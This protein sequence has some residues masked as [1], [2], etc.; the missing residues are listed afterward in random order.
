MPKT[1]FSFGPSLTPIERPRC[2]RCSTGMMLA[3]IA[4]GSSGF[5]IRTFECG[6]C[7]H[8][9]TA[10]VDIDPMKS[11]LVGGWLTGELSVSVGGRG[12]RDTHASSI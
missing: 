3:R 6:K 9:H 10:A 4:P 1:H 12:H 8:V 7:D 5:D 2:P 11:K